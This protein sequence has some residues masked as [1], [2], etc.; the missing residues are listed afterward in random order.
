MVMGLSILCQKIR[1]NEIRVFLSINY[2]LFNTGDPLVE[3]K[4]CCT[5][6]VEFS[7]ESYHCRILLL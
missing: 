1:W 2:S 3:S 7:Y 4:F 6:D 5:A